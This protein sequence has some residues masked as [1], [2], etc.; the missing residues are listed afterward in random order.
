MIMPVDIFILIHSD[1]DVT[2]SKKRYHQSKVGIY[3][4]QN[5]WESLI[6]NVEQNGRVSY[7]LLDC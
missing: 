3:K 7:K 4:L 1:R 2:L 5:R 6:Q